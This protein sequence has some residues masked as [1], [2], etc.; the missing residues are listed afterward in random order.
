LLEFSYFLLSGLN[1]EVNSF[2]AGAVGKVEIPP[3]LRDFQVGKRAVEKTA[4][5][6]SPK[7]GLS[8]H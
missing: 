2:V 3:L 7:A 4:P 8:P 6:K 5:W 1:R